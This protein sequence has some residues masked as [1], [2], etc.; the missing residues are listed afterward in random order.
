M[1]K[2]GAAIGNEVQ[3]DRIGGKHA[4]L[5]DTDYATGMEAFCL[6]VVCVGF[7]LFFLQNNEIL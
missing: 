2:D 5:L 1:H 3:V 4:E 6:G 7:S